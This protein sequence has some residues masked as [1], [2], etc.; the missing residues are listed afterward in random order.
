MER[1]VSHGAAAKP[2]PAVEARVHI[3][4]AIHHRVGLLRGFER[5]SQF[6]F[7]ALVHAVGDHHD[8]LAPHLG[9]QFL[10]RRQVYG[11]VQN[12]AARLPHGGH[13]PRPEA[14]HSRGNAQL[15]Q[16]L[17]EQADRV[18]VILQELGFLA[19]SDQES[20]VLLAQNLRKELGGR[21]AFHADQVALAAAHV[22]Q[23]PDRQRQV[24]LAREILDGLLFAVFEDGEVLGLQVG[25][26]GPVPV[27][28]RG[29]NVHHIDIHPDDRGLLL[30]SLLGS[31]RLRQ[32]RAA[33]GQ[34]EKVSHAG[35]LV[36]RAP[37][38]DCFIVHRAIIHLKRLRPI[39]SGIAGRAGDYRIEF[40]GPD[41]AQSI[42]RRPGHRAAEGLHHL[43]LLN[44][45]PDHENSVRPFFQRDVE[46]VENALI[47]VAPLKRRIDQ[48]AAT[49]SNVSE[50]A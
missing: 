18:G 5:G 11:I 38:Q 32:Q 1:R 26:Q 9:S 12:R 48:L 17:G 44:R 25:Y 14:S 8:H 10:R 23:Q 39:L 35:T 2:I 34:N 7:A 41:P 50:P 16:P 30:R 3:F 47:F 21:A 33:E 31:G 19:E 28:H 40:H 46:R 15:V 43:W 29:Q 45:L 49:L 24:R 22:H 42:S 37:R 27:A 13:R 36:G 6:Q 4:D 20:L